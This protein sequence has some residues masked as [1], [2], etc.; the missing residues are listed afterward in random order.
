MI[1]LAGCD[2]APRKGG[3]GV[4]QPD[5]LT[6]QT[7]LVPHVGAELGVMARDAAAMRG[8]RS[9]VVA[10]VTNDVGVRRVAEIVIAAWHQACTPL[11]SS[12]SST[13]SAR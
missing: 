5:L 1:D 6:N 10:E 4:A 12:S 8:N 3:P 2:E 9:A 7:G 13:K 11:P